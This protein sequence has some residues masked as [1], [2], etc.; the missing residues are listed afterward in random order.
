M[1]VEYQQNGRCERLELLIHALH[2]GEAVGAITVISSDVMASS[3]GIFDIFVSWERLSSAIPIV[4]SRGV[5]CDA[6]EFES[7]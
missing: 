6:E 2:D 7:R 5:K 4:F 3:E 1:T